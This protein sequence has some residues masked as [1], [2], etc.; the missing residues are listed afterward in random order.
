MCSLAPDRICGCFF[1]FVIWQHDS[2]AASCPAPCRGLP[3]IF[4]SDKQDGDG[5]SCLYTLIAKPNNTV[6]VEAHDQFY[7]GNMI[8]D[9]EFLKAKTMNDIENKKPSDR[10]TLR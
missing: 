1:A 2:V 8:D 4:F 7:E 5:T 10:V 6:R 9:W 3:D